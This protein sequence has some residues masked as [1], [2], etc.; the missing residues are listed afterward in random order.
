MASCRS[1]LER[2][3]PDVVATQRLPAGAGG[4]IVG[5]EVASLRGDRSLRN[6]RGDPF[7]LYRKVDGWW[8]SNF[9]RQAQNNAAK[10]GRL[11]PT[12]SNHVIPA[13][14]LRPQ[15]IENLGVA[16]HPERAAGKQVQQIWGFAN[17]R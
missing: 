5:D 1:K 10:M 11:T 9:A 15:A 7:L 17:F 4:S 16:C 8:K 2:F 6:S 13:A 3:E 12:I 14:A